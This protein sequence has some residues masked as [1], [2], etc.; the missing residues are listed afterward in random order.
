MVGGIL[1]NVGYPCPLDPPANDGDSMLQSFQLLIAGVVEGMVTGER[2]VIPSDL[3]EIAR[4]VGAFPWKITDVE[5]SQDKDKRSE[6]TSL[7]R[8]CELYNGRTFT[9]RLGDESKTES[10]VKFEAIGQGHTRRYRFA[11]ISDEPTQ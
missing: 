5:P 2:F 11:K 10:K 3:L 7:A 8:Y 6:R 1:E 9:V 4:H